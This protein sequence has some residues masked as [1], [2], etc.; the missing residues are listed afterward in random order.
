MASLIIKFKASPGLTF[1]ARLFDTSGQQV[2]N[3][4]TDDFV[5][6]S[7]GRYEWQANGSVSETFEGEVRIVNLGNSQVVR[8]VPISSNIV[9]YPPP[10]HP[11]EMSEVDGLETELTGKVDTNDSRLSDARTPTAHSHSQSDVTGLAAALEGKSDTSHTHPGGGITLADV[12]PVGS[13]Y[14]SYLDTNPNAVF[15]FG[16]WIPI[17]SGQALFGVDT[18]QTEFDAA[19]KTGGSKTHTLTVSEMPIHTH[20]QDPH[21][22]LQDSHSHAQ[23]IRNT[24]TAGTAGAQ[25]ANTAN[26]ATAGTTGA[27]TATNQPATAVNQN[28]GGGQAH[29][30]LPPYFCVYIFRRTA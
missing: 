7:P 17:A 20:S 30:N 14:M 8:R 10:A 28:A 21:N 25:G 29:N 1:A 23:Q 2:G 24:G 13:I 4:I 27:A 11:H 22:H 3:D 12:Y 5:E 6:G 15:G 18:G 19:G 26:N 16:T 9:C